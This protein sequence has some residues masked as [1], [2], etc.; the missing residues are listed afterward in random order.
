MAP[1][2]NLN[3]SE[4]VFSKDYDA[5]KIKLIRQNYRRRFLRRKCRNGFSPIS[6]FSDQNWIFQ[7]GTSFFAA[8]NSSVQ[9]ISAIFPDFSK[10]D[11]RHTATSTT[12]QATVGT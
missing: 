2:L 10:I 6:D 4:V 1:G 7:Q 8:E 12:I 5:V 3:V 9:W 11:A